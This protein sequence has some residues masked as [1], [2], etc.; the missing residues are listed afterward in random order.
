MAM[1][2]T[3]RLFRVFV[4]STFE[5]LKQERDAL[6][7]RVFPR[8]RDLCA[9]HAT[10]FQ[11]I[12]LRWG[13]SQEA[14]LDQQTINVCIGEI[15][16][17][18]RS[19]PRPN[20]LVL[21]GDRYGWRP[22]PPEIPAAE[23][24]AIL[25]QLSTAEAD[26][27]RKRDLL[28]QWY[29]RDDNAV[30][31]VYWLLP[32]E[33]EFVD[34]AAWAPVERQLR[35]T[36]WEAVQGLRLAG[37]V[38]LKY[39][40][41]AVEQEAICGA[42]EVPDARDHVFCFLRR[43]SDLPQD[44]TAMPFLDLDDDGTPDRDALTRLADLKNRLRR[45]LDGNI[46]EYAA[47]W[48]GSGVSDDHITALCNDVYTRLAGVIHGALDLEGP[49]RPGARGGPAHQGDPGTLALEVRAHDD[50]GRERPVLHRPDRFPGDHPHLP[51]SRRSTR[52]GGLR[53]GGF[54]QVGVAGPG[55]R[56]GSCRP[57]GRPNR[58]SLHRRHPRVHQ[59]AGAAEQLVAADRSA[60]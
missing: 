58:V 14:A 46:H 29:R 43:I 40:A 31:A 11:A 18:Q 51:G 35:T 36:L 22:P 27:Q 15:K 1:A 17:C 2:Q 23:F 55:D 34:N 39:V 48:T 56:A 20:F 42:L 5:D 7:R 53:S 6:H 54:G 32:R 16:R 24:E 37:P 3:P 47:R 57:P 8:L 50:F 28:S 44:R 26:G 60:R 19:T 49:T 30:P 59:P 25:D 38:S 9:Q 10:R 13:I 52:A 4:C 33:A 12:D 45:R 41:S 21:L